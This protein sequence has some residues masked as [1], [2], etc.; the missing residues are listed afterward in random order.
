LS[1]VI[2]SGGRTPSAYRLRLAGG[3]LRLAR[4][5]AQGLELQSKTDAADEKQGENSPASAAAVS[6][7]AIG[8]EDSQLVAR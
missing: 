3:Y 8:W 4:D 6:G 7:S 1:K 2:V 5:G